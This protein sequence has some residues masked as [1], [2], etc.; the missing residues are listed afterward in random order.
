MI[1]TL[2]PWSCSKT[3]CSSTEGTV[4]LVSHDRTF[5]DNVVTSIIAA[6]GNGLWREYEG[7]VQDWLTQSQRSQ[8]WAEQ[9]QKTP[10]TPTAASA[11][12]IKEEKNHPS[13]RHAPPSASS[14]TKSNANWSNCPHTLKRWR[15]SKP[16]CAPRWQTRKSTPKTMPALSA[17]HA[18]DAEIEAALMLA[19]ER[20][21]ALSS[22]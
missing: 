15:P 21:E 7:S 20:W 8:A 2:K 13:R 17:L 19:L 5:L 14:A 16:A 4:F 22:Q 12:S 18:R 11:P 6:E 9:A 10:A 3:C 1:W